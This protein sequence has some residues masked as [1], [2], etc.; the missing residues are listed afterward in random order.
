MKP[1]NV[2]FN[3]HRPIDKPEMPL[4][5]TCLTGCAFLPH[6]RLKGAQQARLANSTEKVKMTNEAI[7]A[8]NIW[9]ECFVMTLLKYTQVMHTFP[10]FEEIHTP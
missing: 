4:L 7:A 9:P 10:K 2:I 8:R 6:I 3:M 1:W 5:K